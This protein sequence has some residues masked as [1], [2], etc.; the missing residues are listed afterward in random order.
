MT[1]TVSV[2]IPS[3][4][5]RD[6]LRRCLDSLVHQTRVP[7]ETVVVDNGSRD[8]TQAM[9]VAEYPHVQVVALATNIG[10]AAGV[11]AG[12]AASTG[13]VVVLLNND[14]EADP[15]WL[16]ALLEG[17][18]HSDERTGIVTSKIV[19]M[20]DG[21]LETTGDL[22]TTSGVPFGRGAGEPDDGRYA[23][24]RDVF[25]ACGGA[26]AYR[27]CLLD[28]VGLFEPAYFAYFEDVDLCAR[29]RLRG[30]SI[31]YE[32]R[33]RVRH[34]VHGTSDRI[35]GF[36]RRQSLRNGWLLVLRTLPAGLLVR[37]LPRLL[38]FHAW[39]SLVAIKQGDVKAVVTAYRDVL[40]SMPRLRRERR[41]IMRR[42]TVDSGQFARAMTP[43]TL[44]QLLSGPA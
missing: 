38:V 40:R 43:M 19:R 13:D 37:A 31:A 33:A 29:A 27:R 4:D 21:C 15:E 25:S 24:A 41:E 18:D 28:D 42:R 17:L 36:V 32:P 30:W 3:W 23:D 22:L 10:F 1:D 16:A 44:R 34:Q 39:M 12:I 14:V 8:G 7:D 11:N 35:P 9:L 6:L 26:T 2:V 20:A 5:G